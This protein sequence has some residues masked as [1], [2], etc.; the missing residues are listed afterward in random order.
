MNEKELLRL[1]KKVDSAEHEEQQLKGE[2]KA[3]LMNLKEDFDCS[4]SEEAEEA[5]KKLK[6]KRDQLEEKIETKM[7]EITLQYFPDE[8]P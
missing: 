1:K 7:E 6:K 2:R 8:E 4:T 3:I 5:R